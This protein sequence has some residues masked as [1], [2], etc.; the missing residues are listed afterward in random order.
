MKTQHPDESYYTEEGAKQLHDPEK[1][2]KKRKAAS[3]ETAGNKKSKVGE[4]P[5]QEQPHLSKDPRV[6]VPFEPHYQWSRPQPLDAI[7]TPP[8]RV[9]RAWKILER[10]IEIPTE[11]L[12]SSNDPRQCNDFEHV[13]SAPSS[14]VRRVLA[15]GERIYSPIRY[16]VPLFCP[17]LSPP[18]DVP[19]STPVSPSPPSSPIKFQPPSPLIISMPVFDESP[20]PTLPTL[21][22]PPRPVPVPFKRTLQMDLNLQKPWLRRKTKPLPVAAPSRPS[23]TVPSACTV[24][25]AEVTGDWFPSSPSLE[26]EDAVDIALGGA[27]I[28][29]G[30]DDDDEKT[31]GTSQE[32]TVG[33]GIS[34]NPE[35]YV[36]KDEDYDGLDL[37]YY[38]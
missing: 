10:P 7:P 34:A 29:W 28:I 37:D 30:N 19:L 33:S 24:T 6:Y 38:F 13:A 36:W 11:P 25:S 26:T 31:A 9:K 16:P 21:P 2:A 14:P 22:T 35:G 15:S 1:S 8:P 20:L 18:R 12:H 17:E 5:S 23:C 32:D 27:S 4:T 3:E